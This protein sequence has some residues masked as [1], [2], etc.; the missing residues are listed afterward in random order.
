[1][2]LAEIRATGASI[3]LK[4]DGGLG[5]RGASPGIIEAIKQNRA[6]I[7][8]TLK[9]ERLDGI[10]YHDSRVYWSLKVLYDNWFYM[11]ESDERS[12]ALRLCARW[13]NALTDNFAL[14]VQMVV[15]EQPMLELIAAS[16]PLEGSA[17]VAEIKLMS[18]ATHVDLAGATA[19]TAPRASH[20]ALDGPAPI[21]ATKHAR[22]SLDEP[23]QLGLL[24][25]TSPELQLE[26]RR[27][28]Y[29]GLG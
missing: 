22:Q 7:I 16:V 24:D 13:D 3:D 25:A 14:G 8:A 19:K 2:G 28:T 15:D 17:L 10:D 29:A 27:A 18:A 12:N 1:M 26:P 21:P 4:A 23:A 5:V 9:R 11:P 20:A 6:A